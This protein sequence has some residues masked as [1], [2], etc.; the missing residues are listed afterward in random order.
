MLIV[1]VFG[2]AII[3]QYFAFRKAPLALYWKLQRS[4]E[5]YR[6]MNQQITGVEKR[7]KVLATDSML[8]T[9]AHMRERKHSLS[10][11]IMERMERYNHLY[12]HPLKR[13]VLLLPAPPRFKC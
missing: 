12:R 13:H 2:L 10:L 11:F 4:I 8:E 5:V 3:F 6:L 7:M 1:Y 9:L